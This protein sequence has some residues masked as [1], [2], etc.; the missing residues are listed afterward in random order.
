MTVTEDRPGTDAELV[1]AGVAL[2]DVPLGDPR[3]RGTLAAQALDAF[4]PAQTGQE[5]A[6]GVLALELFD[7]LDE[8]HLALDG[9]GTGGA[10]H[11]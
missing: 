1:A 8:V 3:D 9:C 2:V 11:G 6:A 7:Q 5:L 10:W 4:G